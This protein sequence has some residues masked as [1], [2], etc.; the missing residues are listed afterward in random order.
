MNLLNSGVSVAIVSD[1]FQIG[2]PLFTNDNSIAMKQVTFVQESP[3]ALAMA[4]KTDWEACF[5]LFAQD[6]G[7]KT[8]LEM[9]DAWEER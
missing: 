8:Q 9:T 7:H 6:H 3:R 5:K 4:I 1:Q 2:R